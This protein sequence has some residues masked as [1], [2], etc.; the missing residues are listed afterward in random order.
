MAKPVLSLQQSEGIV[1]GAAA[2]IYAAYIAAGRVSE[3]KETE[4]MGRA[5]REAVWIAKATDEAVK[6]DGEMT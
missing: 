2:T 5:I 4:M 6:S 3:G 1:V